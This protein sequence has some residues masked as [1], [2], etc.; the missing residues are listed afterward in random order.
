MTVLVNEM[1]V[2][3]ALGE[4]RREIIGLKKK[5]NIESKVI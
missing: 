5:T 4:V 2:I 3:E 1:A